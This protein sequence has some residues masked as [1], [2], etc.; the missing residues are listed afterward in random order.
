VEA[1]RMQTLRRFA[2]ALFTIT[3][4]S[5]EGGFVIAHAMYHTR[6]MPAMETDAPPAMHELVTMKTQDVEAGPVYIG[7]AELEL[8]ASPAEEFDRLAPR[9][10][11]GAYYRQLGATFAGGTTVE[12][13]HA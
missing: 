2:Q 4:T 9:E 5:D 8:F 1:I 12:R 7:D 3:G 6:Y 11:L 10:I 13:Y